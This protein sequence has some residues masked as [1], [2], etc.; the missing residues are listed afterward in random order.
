MQIIREDILDHWLIIGTFLKYP[1]SNRG[2][3]LL[4]KIINTLVVGC[5]HGLE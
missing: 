4:L 5:Q 2:Q 1:G 3:F